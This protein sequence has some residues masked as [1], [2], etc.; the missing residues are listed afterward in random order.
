MTPKLAY[1]GL[2]LP[3]DDSSTDSDAPP[4]EDSSKRPDTPP[5]EDS[6]TD[7][8]APPVEDSSKRP[9]TPDEDGSS[10]SPEEANFTFGEPVAKAA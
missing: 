1:C 5:K 2:A 6:S 7:S 8:D 3:K 10:S 9:D 4:V